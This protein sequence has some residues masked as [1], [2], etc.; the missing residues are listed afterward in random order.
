MEIWRRRRKILDFL[1][2]KANF[3][4]VFFGEGEV[5]GEGRY[6]KLFFRVN[7]RFVDFESFLAVL[8]E[9]LDLNR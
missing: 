3:G 4:D 5:R 9:K 8:K 7:S 6:E 1:T 2:T